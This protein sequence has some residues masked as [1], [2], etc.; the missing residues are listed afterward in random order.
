ME[1]YFEIL[2]S[3][4]SNQ[5]VGRV[6]FLHARA[7]LPANETTEEKNNSIIII[8]LMSLC[9]LGSRSTI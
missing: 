5:C 2:Q 3:D 9:Y 7:Q 4:N 8:Q 1:N 6:F